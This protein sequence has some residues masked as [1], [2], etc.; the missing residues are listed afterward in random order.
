MS[1]LGRGAVLEVRSEAEGPCAVVLGAGINYAVPASG[2]T[3]E[4]PWIDLHA[5]LD[6]SRHDRSSLAGELAAALARACDEF[7]EQGGSDYLLRWAKYDVLNGQRI[8]VQR[9]TETFAAVAQGIDERGA[10]VVQADGVLHTV[11]SGEVSI[12]KHP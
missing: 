6:L 4:Q 11:Q 5:L 1:V 8:T 10:L 12:R 9:G 3:I 2:L 7:E